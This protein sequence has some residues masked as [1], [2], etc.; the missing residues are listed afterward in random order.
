VKSR[1]RA[2]LV[3]HWSVYSDATVEPITGAIGRMAADKSIGRAE[4][5]RRSMLAL[6]DKGSPDEAHTTFWAPFVVVGEGGVTSMPATE[7]AAPVTGAIGAPVASQA[8]NESKVATRMLRVRPC[9]LSTRGGIY[10]EIPSREIDK[11]AAI[12]KG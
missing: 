5:M 11:Y 10:D 3:S 1:A 9:P 12:S 8:K 4:A 6:I 7:A 2:L